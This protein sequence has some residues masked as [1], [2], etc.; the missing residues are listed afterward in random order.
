MSP[1]KTKALNELD[2]AALEAA[3]KT[4]HVTAQEGP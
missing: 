1:K 2:F 4:G 3:V